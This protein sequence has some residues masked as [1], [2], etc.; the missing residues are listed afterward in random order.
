MVRALSVVETRSMS[1]E[2]YYKITSGWEDGVYVNMDL[3]EYQRRVYV[4][5][6]DNDSS[7][8]N[9]SYSSICLM[10]NDKQLGMLDPWR[11]LVDLK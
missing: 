4:V 2:N 8:S 6:V 1:I 7:L 9:N 10:I 11:R 3:N 5:T